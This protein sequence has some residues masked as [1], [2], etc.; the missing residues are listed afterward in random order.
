M[1][2]KG[3]MDS[4][5]GLMKDLLMSKYVLYIIYIIYFSCSA[6]SFNYIGNY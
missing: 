5:K 6:N 4:K 2:E 3:W 1:N